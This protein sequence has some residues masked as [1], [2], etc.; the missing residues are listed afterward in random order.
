MEL[1]CSKEHRSQRRQLPHSGQ[2]P[3]ELATEIAFTK[4]HFSGEISV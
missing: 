4:D 1:L 3:G 2:S